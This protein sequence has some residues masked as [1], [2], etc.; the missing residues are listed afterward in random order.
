MLRDMVGPSYKENE[1][2]ILRKERER[3]RERE[4]EER[5]NNKKQSLQEQLVWK[6]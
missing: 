6:T 3:E 5:N 1:R 4:R 2:L